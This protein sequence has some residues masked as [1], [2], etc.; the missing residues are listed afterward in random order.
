MQKYYLFFRPGNNKDLDNVKLL[1]VYSDLKGA[2]IDLASFVGV[3][4]AT[5][6]LALSVEKYYFEDEINT[7]YESYYFPKF[8]HVKKQLC[9]FEP[10]HKNKRYCNTFVIIPVIDDTLD[11]V[12]AMYQEVRDQ[13]V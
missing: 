7:E 5:D 10:K 6:D 11:G 1:N 4:S 2:H 8:D 12:A 9:R 3:K 13:V